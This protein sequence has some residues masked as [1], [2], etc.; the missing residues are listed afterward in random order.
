[1][2]GLQGGLC[3][4]IQAQLPPYPTPFLV[5]TMGRGSDSHDKPVIR[6]LEK[7]PGLK[8]VSLSHLVF[9]FKF[10]FEPDVL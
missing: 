3:G 6:R 9:D 5:L 10:S 4:K 1:M 2:Q 8:S 7:L